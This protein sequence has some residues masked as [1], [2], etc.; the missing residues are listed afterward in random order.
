MPHA[1]VST[2]QR[3]RAKQLRQSMTRAETLLWRY[4]KAH[5]VDGLAFRRQVPMRGYIADF[6]CHAAK[7]VVEIDGATHSTDA[8]IASDSRRTAFLRSEG[9]RVIRFTNAEV[10]ANLDGVLET[11]LRSLEGGG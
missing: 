4:L 7:V 10:F 11:I 1:K 6:I 2:H 5:H 9:F 8:E 3:E